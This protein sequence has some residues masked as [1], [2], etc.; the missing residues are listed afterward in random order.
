[1]PSSA[2]TA[3]LAYYKFAQLLVLSLASIATCDF[4][5]QEAEVAAALASFSSSSYVRNVVI[6]DVSH[7]EESQYFHIYYGQTFKVI[8]NGIDGKS[9]LLMQ[10]CQ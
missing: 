2:N 10:V 1:M 5:L 3:S 8:K 9:Y 6:G 4:H 7:V